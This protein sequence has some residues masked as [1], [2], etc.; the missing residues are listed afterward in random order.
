MSVVE[1]SSDARGIVTLMINRPGSRNALDSATM[2]LENVLE[3]RLGPDRAGRHNQ[4][5]KKGAEHGH[6]F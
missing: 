6:P 2:G 5:D 4:E 3:A 1:R